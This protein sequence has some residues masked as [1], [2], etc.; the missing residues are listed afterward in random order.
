MISILSR[1][2]KICWGSDSAVQ[3]LQK[4]MIFTWHSSS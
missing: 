4:H 3:E 1:Q 2:I